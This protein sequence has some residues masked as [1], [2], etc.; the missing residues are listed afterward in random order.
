MKEYPDNW[1]IRINRNLPAIG[2]QSGFL[3]LSYQGYIANKK[4][5]LD[6]FANSD[7]DRGHQC[8]PAAFERYAE[9]FFDDLE[10]KTIVEIKKY[11]S[12]IAELD[13]YLNLIR[14][15]R[16]SSEEEIQQKA[17]QDL[18]TIRLPNKNW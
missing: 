10:S 4:Q 2:R 12:K 14:S 18:V 9:H 13:S 16:R 15:Q 7:C 17:H 6:A 5:L 3:Y 1:F 11:Q 8:N